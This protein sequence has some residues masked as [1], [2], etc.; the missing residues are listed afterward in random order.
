MYKDMPVIELFKW[1]HECCGCGACAAVCPNGAINMYR[2]GE[3]FLYPVVSADKCTGCGLCLK[4]CRSSI[5]GI[6]SDC[7]L[8][9]FA[10]YCLDEETRMA[11]SSGGVFSV[12]AYKILR[13]GGVVYGAAFDEGFSVRH[14][15]VRDVEDLPRL[16][17]SKYVQSDTVDSFHNVKSDLAAG[18]T[19]LFS[20]TPCQTAEL[21]NYLGG[22]HDGLLTVDL[23]CH[24]VPSPVVWSAY[25]NEVCSGMDYKAIDKISFRDKTLSWQNY[26]VLFVFND[27]TEYR[28]VGRCDPYIQGFLRNLYLR[29]SCHVCRFKG[30]N[31]TSDI[32]LADF[33]GIEDVLPEMYDGKG[34]SLVLVNTEKGAKLWNELSDKLRI[35]EVD[36]RAALAH[37]DAALVSVDANLSREEFFQEFIKGTDSLEMLVARY[38]RKK[39]LKKRCMRAINSLVRSLLAFSRHTQR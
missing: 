32:T 25:V 39:P 18:K 1:K 14:I 33:W 11:S 23:V 38:A 20:G 31:R 22:R 16:R 7:K 3:G 8:S 27:R 4:T 30:N 10:A 15:A 2:D 5:S 34:T 21:L 28:R 26:S 36:V 24:G 37:N 6:E 29:P 12:L 13:D 35:S 19:V 17:G 9:A